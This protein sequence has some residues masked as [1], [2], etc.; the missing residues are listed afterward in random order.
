MVD[1]C[2]ELALDEARKVDKLIQSGTKDAATLEKELPFLGVPFTIKDCFSVKGEKVILNV[3]VTLLLQHAICLGMRYTAGLVKRRNIVGQFDA[4]VV[5]LMK[6]AGAIHLAVTNVS[7]LCMWWESHNRV[8][9][10]SRNPYDVNRI[11]G[12]SSGG[13]VLKSN[14]VH[15]I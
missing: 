5:A 11:V 2:F 4:D 9:G 12:G 14:V 13:E 8:Y 7:E 10:R 6:R 15:T 1:N 3:I